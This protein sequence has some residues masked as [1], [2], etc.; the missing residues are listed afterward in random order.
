MITCFGNALLATK[1]YDIAS[2]RILI[3]MTGVPPNWNATRLGFCYADTLNAF[4]VR[5]STQPAKMYRIDAPD[6]S[7]NALTTPWHVSE[8]DLT[9]VAVPSSS[10]IFKR[11]RWT[12]NHGLVWCDSVNTP[13][14]SYTSSGVSLLAPSSLS[15][16]VA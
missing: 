6:P 15:G 1:L 7:Q 13:T 10:G 4:F 3:Q 5:D 2:D 14:Y 12:K 9:G 8:I 16:Q 11:M